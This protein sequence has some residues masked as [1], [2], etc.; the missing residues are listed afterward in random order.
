MDEE[1]R[2]QRARE[3]ERGVDPPPSFKPARR[4]QLF[5]SDETEGH[6]VRRVQIVCPNDVTVDSLRA[7]FQN[8]VTLRTC[9]LDII[10]GCHTQVDFIHCLVPDLLNITNCSFYWGKYLLEIG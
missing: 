8:N 6:V 3:I 10:T 2:I 4:V 5:C 9:P 7:I 1:A